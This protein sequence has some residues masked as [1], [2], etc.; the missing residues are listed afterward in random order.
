MLHLAQIETYAVLEN[1]GVLVRI[2]G[3]FVLAAGVVGAASG[4]PIWRILALSH[5][6]REIR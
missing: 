2:G 4:V 5:L 1:T 6:R 3:L